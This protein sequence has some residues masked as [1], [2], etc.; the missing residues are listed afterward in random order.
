MAGQI[1]ITPEQYEAVKEIAGRECM[2]VAKYIVADE[3]SITPYEA[4]IVIL[5]VMQHI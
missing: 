4:E 1:I 2:G 5:E 3:L